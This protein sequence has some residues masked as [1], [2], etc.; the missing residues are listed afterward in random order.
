MADFSKLLR[1]CI[2]KNIWWLE[3]LN[4]KHTHPHTDPGKPTLKM[5][6]E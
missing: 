1:L 3:R 4:H 5:F 6:S 2:N